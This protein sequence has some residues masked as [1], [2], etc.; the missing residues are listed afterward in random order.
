MVAAAMADGHIDAGEQARIFEQVDQQ[1]LPPAEKAA[2][3]DELRNPL[4]LD[5][6][7]AQVRDPESAIEVYA[8]SVLA[9]DENLPAGQAYLARLASALGL[10]DDLVAQLHAGKQM[11]HA[12]GEAA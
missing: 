2:L 5:A 8:A 1:G 12:E 4:S 11:E 7:V 9:V 10:P 6:L 3:F